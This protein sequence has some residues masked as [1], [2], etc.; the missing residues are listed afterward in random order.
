MCIPNMATYVSSDSVLPD[1]VKRLAD[2]GNT[3]SLMAV[4]FS[5]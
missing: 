4:S 5:N 2:E 3:A 1:S